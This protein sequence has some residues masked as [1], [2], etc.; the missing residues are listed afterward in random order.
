MYPKNV[1]KTQEPSAQRVS[2]SVIIRWVGTEREGFEPSKAARPYR[3]SRPAPSTTR[4][5]LPATHNRGM[6]NLFPGPFCRTF[7]L[8]SSL[9]SPEPGH[10]TSE[11]DASAR[12]CHAALSDSEC[13]SFIWTNPRN[14]FLRRKPAP[15]ERGWTNR[16]KTASRRSSACGV[17]ATSGQVPL[18][19]HTRAAM[20][21][22]VARNVVLAGDPSITPVPR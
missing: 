8:R 5:P 2:R 3:F 11:P 22:L 13:L 17:C 16:W 19:R 20:A 6:G 21:S 14:P 9:G 12:R 1:P 10:S 4:T 7:R 15:G 18:A